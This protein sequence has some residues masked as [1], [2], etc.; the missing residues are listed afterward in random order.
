MSRFIFALLILVSTNA[1]AESNAEEKEFEAQ[2]DYECEKARAKK[3][4]PMRLKI[5]DDCMIKYDNKSYCNAE[6]GKYNA[7][8][9]NGSPRFYDLPECVKVF[10]YR[11]AHRS[12]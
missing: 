7:E 12:R 1:F 3:L 6:A 5:F 10:E 2:L 4:Y 9:V 11:K 8:R